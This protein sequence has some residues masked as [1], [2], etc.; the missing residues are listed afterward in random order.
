[1]T[2]ISDTAENATNTGEAAGELE[3]ADIKRIMEL[4]PHRYPMLLIDRIVDMN[5]TDSAVGIKNVTINDNFF[6]G[7]FPTI[8]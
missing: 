5:G 8:Q 7:I 1:M 4:L 3:T 2:N 6:Q